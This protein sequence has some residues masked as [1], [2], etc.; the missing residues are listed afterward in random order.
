MNLSWKQHY[1]RMNCTYTEL[2]YKKKIENCEVRTQKKNCI[3]WLTLYN[4]HFWHFLC[5]Y[6]LEKC[7]LYTNINKSTQRFYVKMIKVGKFL[8]YSNIRGDLIRES[9][10]ISI[11]TIVSEPLSP[12]AT[13][14]W[15]SLAKPSAF[16]LLTPTNIFSYCVYKVIPWRTKLPSQKQRRK[17]KLPF[18]SDTPLYYKYKYN[19][20]A[21][22]IPVL[23]E[24]SFAI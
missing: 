20:K 22:W 21:N 2:N 4:F 15:I 10:T 13:Q 23:F 24:K 11:L 1:L 14:I 9:M 7:V 19:R 5:Q 17:T 16:W 6:A 18:R 3:Q 8:Q 12:L